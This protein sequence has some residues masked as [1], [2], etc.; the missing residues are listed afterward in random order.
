MMGEINRILAPGG[1]LIL[2]TPNISSLRALSAIFAGYHPGFFPAYIRPA[3]DGSV[4]ARHAREYTPREI[5]RLLEDSGLEVLTLDTG[6]FRQEAS[7]EFLWVESI[8][9]WHDLDTRYRGECIFAVGR[10]VAAAKQRYPD[11]LYSG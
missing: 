5:Y 8:L 1:V 4:D 11:W 2:T 9:A 6:P 3:E 10:K 7:A